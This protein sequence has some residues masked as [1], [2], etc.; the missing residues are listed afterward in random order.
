[1]RW[2]IADERRGYEDKER[3]E[4]SWLGQGSIERRGR[5]MGN[6]RNAIMICLGS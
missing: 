4:I 1:M 5:L 3:E 2:C 6:S